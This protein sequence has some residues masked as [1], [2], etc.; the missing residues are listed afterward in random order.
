[1]WVGI[2]YRAVWKVMSPVRS[3]ERCWCSVLGASL[4]CCRPVLGLYPSGIRVCFGIEM[5]RVGCPVA[6]GLCMGPRVAD[7]VGTRVGNQ[8]VCRIAG[9]LRR[10]CVVVLSLFVV[11]PAG[12]V[13]VAR[14]RRRL[15]VVVLCGYVVG[16]VS[17]SGVAA[18]RRCCLWVCVLVCLCVSVA[19]VLV[20]PVFVFGIVV[21][22]GLVVLVCVCRRRGPPLR[23]VLV[24]WLR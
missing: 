17:C 1:M 10:R 8:V 11:G 2:V 9:F 7:W 23:C 12:V 18:S 19:V 21:F 15:V 14:C 16:L 20:L 22:V 4:G 5:A 24:C 3:V 6:V 13:V